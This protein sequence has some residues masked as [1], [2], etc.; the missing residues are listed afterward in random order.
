[1]AHLDALYGYAMA[2]TR[3]QLDAEDLVQEACLRAIASARRTV[4]TGN[5]KA[6]LFTILRNAWRN[7]RRRHSQGPVFLSFTPALLDDTSRQVYLMG[8]GDNARIFW[9]SAE[10]QGPACGRPS[11]AS[12]HPFGR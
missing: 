3:D 5:V 1:M 10:A 6:W 2:L 11:R 12:R 4:P 8:D 7:R 9:W